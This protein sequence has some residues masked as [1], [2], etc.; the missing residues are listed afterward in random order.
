LMYGFI[1]SSVATDFLESMF[2]PPI[3]TPVRLS[4]HA[5]PELVGIQSISSSIV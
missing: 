5:S 4:V 3:F 1:L 2:S